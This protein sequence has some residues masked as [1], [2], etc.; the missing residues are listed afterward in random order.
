[1]VAVNRR[2]KWSAST[3]GLCSRTN[4]PFLSWRNSSKVTGIKSPKACGRPSSWFRAFPAKAP[5]VGLS[6]R[7]RDWCASRIPRSAGK[8]VARNCPLP[9][10]CAGQRIPAYVPA[11]G[12][13]LR[14][15]K[16]RPH[17]DA[18]G[19][20][21]AVFLP[22]VPR[23]KPHHKPPVARPCDRN[24]RQSRRIILVNTANPV[25]EFL[26]KSRRMECL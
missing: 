6:P 16:L 3:I 8:N 5:I 15:P 18:R 22:E 17:L 21:S 24:N 25:F 4:G 2:G 26:P 10:L 19:F 7:L 20:L 23:G 11:T 12:E 1:M 14:L 13:Y 9:L